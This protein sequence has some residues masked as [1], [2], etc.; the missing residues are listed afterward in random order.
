MDTRLQRVDE[1]LVSIQV[2]L[3]KLKVIV[4]HLRSQPPQDQRHL[5][6]TIRHHRESL[7]DSSRAITEQIEHICLK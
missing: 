5:K 3:Q 4:D 7:L 2:E 1:Q 6:D